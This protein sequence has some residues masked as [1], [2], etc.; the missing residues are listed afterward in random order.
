MSTFRGNLEEFARIS[1]EYPGGVRR[2]ESEGK[3]V[4]CY[5]GNR[6]PVEIIH[7]SGA[8]PYPLFDGGDTGP[9]EAALPYLLPFI[10]VQTLYQVGQ[11]ASGLNP[12]T[13]IAD[14]II[15]DCKESEEPSDW[16]GLDAG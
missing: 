8:V 14:L 10:N 13:P 7:A 11:H 12:I 1:R 4:V 3:R 2:R 9:S 5:Y 15:I 16:G 6:V